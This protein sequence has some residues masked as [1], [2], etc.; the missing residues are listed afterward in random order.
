M[1]LA[2]WIFLLHVHVDILRP[3]GQ[4]EHMCIVNRHS[5]SHESRARLMSPECPM[6]GD[7][8]RLYRQRMT[9]RAPQSL[10]REQREPLGGDGK[11]KGG[12]LSWPGLRT[13][14]KGKS[15]G[16]GS[17][18]EGSARS[19]NRC[20]TEAFSVLWAIGVYPE[21]EN[22]MEDALSLTCPHWAAAG[23]LGLNSQRLE[24]L[25]RAHKLLCLS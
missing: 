22:L 14:W 18:P 11:R 6:Q 10:I 2:D 4:D 17:D 9:A 5:L 1:L 19:K 16:Q 12:P 20:E 23:Q 7:S 8:L 15:L 13:R 24:E 21:G 25:T 3:K